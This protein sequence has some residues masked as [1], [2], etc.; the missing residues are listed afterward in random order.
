[1]ILK[2]IKDISW[3]LL[4]HGIRTI[5]SIISSILIINYFSPQN[6]GILSISLSIYAVLQAISSLGL[7]SILLKKLIELTDYSVIAGSYKLRFICSILISTICLL[8]LL[9]LDNQ[10]LVILV[11]L[12]VS[13]YFDSFRALKELA[14]SKKKYTSIVYSNSIASLIQLISVAL[15]VYFKSSLYWFALPFLLKSLTFIS[16][17]FSLE[18]GS[19]KNTLYIPKKIDLKLLKEGIPLMIASIAGLIYAVQDQWM[20]GIF[21]TNEDVGIYSAGVK[22][23]LILL[24][25]PTIVTNVLYHKI[26][27]LKESNNF[28]SYMQSLYSIL[29][30]FG[31]VL[32][33]GMYFFSKYIIDLIF[34]ETYES[35]KEVL[36]VY[37]IILIMA[38][39]QSLNNKLLILFNNQKL[40]MQR[41]LLSL[42]FNLLFN[43]YL[44]KNYGIVGAALATVL[45]EFIVLISYSFNKSTRN[46]F[47]FQ[48]KAIN[49]THI[50][51][52]FIISK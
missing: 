34:P 24:I 4:E 14:F 29:F 52:I 20:I 32:Y 11:I 28:D 12:I 30:Y 15:L 37:S 42:I 13:L 6:Y 45:S 17:L 38:F 3:F 19:A 5:C 10:W 16:I 35:S 36:I 8:A 22:F 25:L 50:K 26:I 41:V 9:F 23:V 44:I 7:D 27:N 18:W 2:L 47:I 48:I 43:L 1:M 31:L 46:I 40:I 21:M 33:I 49:P 39:F 51:N